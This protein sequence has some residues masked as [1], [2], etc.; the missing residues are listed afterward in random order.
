MK[1]FFLKTLWKQED[2]FLQQKILKI[3]DSEI[4]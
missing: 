1:P 4:L 2:V 3:I